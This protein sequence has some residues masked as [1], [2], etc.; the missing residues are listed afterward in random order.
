MIEC[1][2]KIPIEI[3]K[4]QLEE[5]KVN[6][7]EKFMIIFLED[8]FNIK[9]IEEG[10]FSE[11]C[12]KHNLSDLQK[13]F[14]EKFKEYLGIG[15]F[16]NLGYGR[17]GIGGQE[18]L[19]T[20]SL[21]HYNLK[22]DFLDKVRNGIKSK[23]GN[24][25]IGA[26]LKALDDISKKE[27]KLIDTYSDL[28]FI[29]KKIINDFFLNI[30]YNKKENKYNIKLKNAKIVF[31]PMNNNFIEKYNDFHKNYLAIKS[32][33]EEKEFYKFPI[34]TFDTMQQTAPLK[35][36]YS[37][38]NFNNLIFYQDENCNPINKKEFQ[39]I[40][41]FK[42]IFE[43]KK[44]TLLPLPNFKV[45]KDNIYVKCFSD[46]S[47]LDKLKFIYEKNSNIPYNYTLV[48]NIMYVDKSGY[49]F[50]NVTNFDFLI[51]ELINERIYDLEFN[52]YYDNKQKKEIEIN[53]S[54][55][56]THDKYELLFDI[57]SIFWNLKDEETAKKFQLS[58][59]TPNIKNNNYINQILQENSENIVA[60]LF[61]QNN[62]FLN[63]NLKNVILKILNGLFSVE[64][65]RKKYEYV[66]NGR[67]LL[68]CYYKY[69]KEN[70][71][72]LK[73]VELIKKIEQ[74]LK[75]FNRDLKY[76][77]I[78]NDLEGYYLAGQILSYILSRT[79]SGKNKLELMTKYLISVNNVIQLKNKI[80]ELTGKYSHEIFEGEKWHKINEAF[81]KYE[82][83]DIVIRNNLIGLFTGFYADNIFYEKKDKTN[84]KGGIENG[85]D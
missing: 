50:E 18:G 30:I 70:Y 75:D 12:E 49:R 83:H 81:L 65:L 35:Q 37:K 58:F 27:I 4:G 21:L 51:D 33:K 26:T 52:K 9:N 60:L 6:E 74:K 80:C 38:F 85:S 1:I 19:F 5:A 28:K 44:L 3:L 62:N 57:A 55:R 23:K 72:D 76:A 20:C 82:F 45:S 46:S 61:K 78:E 79:S 22:D 43:K 14:I 25:K 34:D 77:D 63:F 40:D 59:F 36:L 32:N 16:G 47:L 7:K 11:I 15:E 13:E 39:S 56:K 54:E 24:T 73:M 69:T 48:T 2:T 64:E 41:F 67:R 42:K 71:G 66:P 17:K 84:D 29:L 10:T 68:L 53:N 31:L 8:N